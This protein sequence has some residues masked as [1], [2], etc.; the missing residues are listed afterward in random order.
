MTPNKLAFFKNVDEDKY[1]LDQI[2]KDI[3]IYSGC[4]S[5]A[6]LFDMQNYDCFFYQQKATKL[7]YNVV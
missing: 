7:A 2:L 4:R 5:V 6:N 1:E 3:Q